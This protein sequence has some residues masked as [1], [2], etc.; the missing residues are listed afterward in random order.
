MSKWNLKD[1]TSVFCSTYCSL[2]LVAILQF[3]VV[4]FNDVKA[5]IAFQYRWII[6]V[7]RL[8]SSFR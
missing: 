7:Q 2:L 8:E 3:K 5:A 4:F 6:S 1:Q